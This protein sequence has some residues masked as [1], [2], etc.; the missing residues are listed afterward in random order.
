MNYNSSFSEKTSYQDFLI[1][2]PK[3]FV[4]EKVSKFRLPAVEHFYHLPE[5][6]AAKQHRT[7]V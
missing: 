2:L 4:Y 1:A 5:A 7:R 3:I 6:A